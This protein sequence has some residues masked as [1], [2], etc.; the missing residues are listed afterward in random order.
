MGDEATTKN[1][2]AM[3]ETIEIMR[4][5]LDVLEQERGTLSNL[6]STL[7]SEMGQLRAMAAVVMA[8]RGSGPTAG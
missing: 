5:R 6:V 2:A 4:G 7:L 1:L 8:S 3:A